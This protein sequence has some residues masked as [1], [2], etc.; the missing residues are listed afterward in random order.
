MDFGTVKTLLDQL[1]S[2]TG[3]PV[4]ITEYDPSTA[5]DNAQLSMYQEHIPYFLGLDYVRGITIWGWI[6]VHPMF[7]YLFP[8]TYPHRVMFLHVIEK[9]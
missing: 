2:E 4:Y 8:P 5:D 7:S 1:H 9:P 3:L 6:F